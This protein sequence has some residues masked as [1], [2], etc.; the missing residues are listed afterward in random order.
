MNILVLNCGSSSIKFALFKEQRKVIKGI[1]ERVGGE[2]AIINYEIP[3][4]DIKQKNV[5]SVLNHQEGIKILINEILPQSGI[6]KIDAVGHRV[7]HGG[8]KYSLP[9]I[10]DDDVKKDIEE[11]IPMAPLHNPHHL[12]GIIAIEN[13][14]PKIPN[15]A[16]FDTAF[17]QTIPDE[18]AIYGLPY[19]YYEKYKIKKYGFHGTSHYY[20]MLKTAEMLKTKVEKLKI[21]TC[22]LGN[23]SSITAI[24]YGKSID[25]SM[26]FTPAA[27]VL[28]GTRTGDIDP[29]IVSYIQ[30]LEGLSA[31]DVSVI[32]NKQSGL[33]GVSG[34]SND[35]R[36]II[37][38]M[39]ENSRAELA[40]KMFCYT[41]K[42]YI[43]MYIGI[44]NGA[45]AIIFSA[46]IGENSFLVRKEILKNM[47]NLGIILDH[48]LN[49]K[50]ISKD[51]IISSKKS[52]IK[53]LTIRTDEEFMIAE[54]TKK[55]INC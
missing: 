4:R 32:I 6:E 42:K 7:V 14:L 28:M 3:E 33:L 21:I 29:E 1:V 54:F 31:K 10:I 22:H 8:E 40:F 2:D 39:K 23:G 49:E 51:S 5:V 34:I 41:V 53:V 38:S 26:G 46:G 13:F 27:G 48:K 30:I 9:V 20:L 36:K 19:K 47:E 16:V 45:D 12:S 35:M 52:K 43:S 50:S 15:V 25:T 24:R 11:C 18:A 17:F 37:D 44:L 55:I